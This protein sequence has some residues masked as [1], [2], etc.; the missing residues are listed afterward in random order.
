MNVFQYAALTLMG[1]LFA[2]D[3]V[4]AWRGTARR[5]IAFLRCAVWLATALAIGFPEVVQDLATAIGIGRGA[6]VVLYVFVLAFLLTSFSLYSR[7]VR[8]Q[9]QVT[10]LIR[11]IALAEAQRGGRDG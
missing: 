5:G 8:L 7:Q 10:E 4:A 1:C 6:D 2:W 3:L 9:R 11:H